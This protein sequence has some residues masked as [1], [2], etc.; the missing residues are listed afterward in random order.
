[1]NLG[2]AR[3]GR[4]KGKDFEEERPRTPRLGIRRFGFSC[5]ATRQLG[6]S[7]KWLF[8]LWA[9]VP[10]FEKWRYRSFPIVVR[11]LIKN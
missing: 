7:G 8:F 2:K 5:S 9:L 3:P 4:G 10:S 1:M 6:N 11:K